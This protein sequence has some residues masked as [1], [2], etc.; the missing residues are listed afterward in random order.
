MK[1]NIRLLLLNIKI[2]IFKKI[3]GNIKILKEKYLEKKQVKIIYNKM[4]D[5][6]VYKIYKIPYG[7]LYFNKIND[8][9]FIKDNYLLEGPSLQ[10]RKINNKNYKDDAFGNSF[11][12][13]NVTLKI[14]TPKLIKKI[15]GTVC[16]LLYT[17]ISKDNYFHWLNDVLPKLAILEKSGLIKKI[18]YFLVPGL[19]KEYQISSLKKLNITQNKLIDATVYQHIYAKKLISIEHIYL[20]KNF[21]EDVKTIPAWLSAWFKNR[22]IKKNTI[23]TQKIYITR[24]NS[25]YRKILNEDELIKL[26]VSYSFKIISLEN[27]SFN[28]QIKTFNKSKIVVGVHGAALS[29]SFFQKK[30]TN[31]IEIAFENSN[32]A[33][34]G[35]AKSSQLKYFLIPV[36]KTK[37]FNRNQDGE[38]IVNLEKIKS[39]LAKIK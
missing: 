30:N 7:R 14:N 8:T 26:L 9:A 31:I 20:K 10:V 36:K 11:V 16:S 19:N 13:N 18:D 29:N 32:S 2:F 15:N 6:S 34:K 17:S 12:K 21:V 33:I 37:V 39:I 1:K 5:G 23:A 38:G 27:M 28:Q 24:K 25:E 22:F 35:I 3:Y 4:N